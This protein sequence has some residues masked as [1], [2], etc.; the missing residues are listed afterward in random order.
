MGYAAAR[1]GLD[2]ILAAEELM[3]AKR[4]GGSSPPLGIDQVTE[5]AR[6]RGRHQTRRDADHPHAWR[7]LK[8]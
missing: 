1:G 2:A 4:N 8:R 3:L 5:R 6:H 7:Q